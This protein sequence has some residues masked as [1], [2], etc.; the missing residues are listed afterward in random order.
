M[1]RA[2]LAAPRAD[3][4]A[5][6]PRRRA[7]IQ[8]WEG[9]RHLASL[10]ELFLENQSGAGMPGNALACTG[11]LGLTLLSCA[12]QDWPALP[13]R[14]GERRWARRRPQAASHLPPGLT[15]RACIVGLPAARRL[16]D[17]HASA[18]A[19]APV[20]CCSRRERVH[21]QAA[22]AAPGVAAPRPARAAAA[23]GAG[24]A[25]AD[26]ADLAQRDQLPGS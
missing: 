18:R 13:R 20:R 7:G 22:V 19:R 24:G 21:R 17:E 6:Q 1:R 14:Y 10:R 12:V 25:R 3:V 8:L 4:L 15:P 9:L 26:L 11:L 23:V 16:K 2:P 5:A